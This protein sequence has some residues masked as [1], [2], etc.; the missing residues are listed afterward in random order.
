V[1]GIRVLRLRTWHGPN[2][3]RFRRVANYLSFMMAAAGCGR[4]LGP[5][6]LVI[7]TS[8]HFFSGLAGYGLSRARKAPWV[9]EIRDIWPDSIVAV[10]AA[11]PSPLL[12]AIAR[13]A[14]WAYHKSDRIVSVSPGFSEHFSNYGVPPAKV[15]LAANGV[16]VKPL[17]AR[18]DPAAVPELAALAGRF[19]V[20]YMGTFGMAHGLQTVLDAAELL[21][22]DPRIGFLLAG[23][24]AERD[25]LFAR[26]A[27]RGLTNVVLLDQQPRARV[28]ELWSAA[29]ASIV[30]LK[31]KPVFETVI[32]TK[33][34][35]GMAMAKPILLGVRGQA[36]AIVEAAD[37]GV[38]FPPENAPALAD[39]IV[40]MA[41]DPAGSR[42]LGENGRRYVLA[43][44]D[45]QRMAETYLEALVQTRRDF[46]AKRRP[47]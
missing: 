45:R 9:L 27:E 18:T 38:T 8:P 24:G 13:L 46:D 25:L 37:A 14:R 36:Q 7:S 3:G 15:T 40:S 35:E 6:D 34:L 47:E 32:P 21:K 42:R 2:A 44:F 23:S 39:A 31:D 33:L 12:T 22:D 29:D 4:R 20:A 28:A 43:N 11:K 1:E 16:E 19:I 41:Q 5:V 26:Q 17:A 30:H 10:G